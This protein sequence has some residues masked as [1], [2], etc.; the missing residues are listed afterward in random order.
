MPTKEKQ[1]QP[2]VTPEQKAEARKAAAARAAETRKRNAA[3]KLADNEA[4]G[5]GNGVKPSEAAAKAKPER[6]PRESS[7]AAK[8]GVHIVERAK[9][10]R[11]IDGYKSPTGLAQHA[12]IDKT[13]KARLK[14]ANEEPSPVALLAQAGA[15]NVDELQK[16][17]RSEGGRSATLSELTKSVPKEVA[18]RPRHVAASLVAWIWQ[19]E[20]RTPTKAE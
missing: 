9:L 18:T 17:A 5:V 11:E 16:F 12:A 6:Q 2:T 19:L 15:A 8:Y 7:R 14:K 1:E 20:G 3:Q 10:A 13:L 4:N